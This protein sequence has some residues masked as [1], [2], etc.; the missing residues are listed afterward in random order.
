LFNSENEEFQKLHRQIID[1]LVFLRDESTTRM[2][3]DG[4]LLNWYCFKEVKQNWLGFSQSGN[5]GS[6]LGLD[7]AIALDKNLGKLFND[8]GKEKV[9]KGSHLEKL[10]LIHPGVGRDNISDFTTN[11]IKDFLLRY[12]E[13]FTKDYI[14]ANKIAEFSVPR[15]IF[16]YTTKSWV[17][18]KY[19]LPKYNKDY[20]ILTPKDILTKDETWICRPDMINDFNHIT[21]ALPNKALR[22]QLNE[23]LKS[24][25]PQKPSRRDYN[26]A[27]SK[28]I[29][30]NPEFIEYYIKYKEENGDQAIAISE[31]NVKITEF[32]FIENVKKLV[33]WLSDHTDFY[34]SSYDTYSESLSRIRYLKQVIE[35]NDGYR[36]FYVNGKPIKSEKELQ[37][38]FR[39]TWYDT[40]SDVNSEVNNGRGP[41]DYKVSRGSKDKTV[42]EFK[43]A[44]NSQLE[45]NLKKQAEIYAYANCTKKIIKVI[46]FFSYEEEL[47]VKEILEELKMD[48]NENVILIDAR[49]DNKPSASKA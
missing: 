47:K 36:I 26:D 10:C 12:T 14:S 15:A 46:M 25:L 4:L 37:L 3:T 44:S 38:I 7:F 20:I 31:E 24:V 29:K 41:V 49:N 13:Q 34:K 42:I 32:I 35:N 45:R 19:I 18:K 17:T 28:T 22:E 9:A 2:I 27:V 48:K 5:T 23:Y 21:E 11:L 8:F 1:Y 30:A 40:L 39:L 16:N 43:L 6:G 33:I